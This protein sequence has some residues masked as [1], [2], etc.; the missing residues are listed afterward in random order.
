VAADAAARNAAWGNRATNIRSSRRGILWED[1]W[2]W[3]KTPKKNWGDDV[4]VPL[5]NQAM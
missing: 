2:G 5:V 4:A 3:L 1:I